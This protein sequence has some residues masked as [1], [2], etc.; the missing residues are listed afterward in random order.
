MPRCVVAEAEVALAMRDLSGSAR[1][2]AAASA[3]LAA[4]GDHANAMQAQ[5]IATRRLLLLGRLGEAAVALTSIDTH[6][7]PALLAAVAELTA[8]ELALQD[9]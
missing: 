7:L 8:A 3:A 4:H 5:L 2:L 6:G 1:S 9:P